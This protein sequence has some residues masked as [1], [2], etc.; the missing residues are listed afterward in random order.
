MTQI[1]TIG[2]VEGAIFIT[3]EPENIIGITVKQY[4][5][6]RI[7]PIPA[8]VRPPRTRRIHMARLDGS[9]HETYR[10]RQDD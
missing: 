8:G 10:W 2:A 1:E 6:K 4:M 3:F 5:A 7:L 9:I